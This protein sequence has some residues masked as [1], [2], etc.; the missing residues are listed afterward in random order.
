M[1]PDKSYADVWMGRPTEAEHHLKLQ[2]D[3]KDV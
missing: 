3:P 2:P 1:Q